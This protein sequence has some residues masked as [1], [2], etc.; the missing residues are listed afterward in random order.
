[1][2]GFRCQSFCSSKSFC[3][4]WK[5]RTLVTAAQWSLVVRNLSITL[6]LKYMS[7][8]R[9][10]CSIFDADPMFSCFQLDC[11]F[12]ELACWS[13]RCRLDVI[14]LVKSA[15]TVS[16]EF[17]LEI[18]VYIWLI[19]YGLLRVLRKYFVVQKLS[20]AVYHQAI[21]YRIKT[22]LV[23]IFCVVWEIEMTT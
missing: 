6:F 11:Q 13:S 18:R 12:T 15:R 16:R 17:Y 21:A 14:M 1:M 9:Q 23:T 3:L 22:L 19:S 7:F 20:Y 4:F 5:T 2:V 8:S 10:I